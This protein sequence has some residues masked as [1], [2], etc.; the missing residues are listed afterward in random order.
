MLRK[1]GE[2]WKIGAVL[3]GLVT[4]ILGVNAY[5]YTSAKATTTHGAMDKRITRNTLNT[6]L[7]KD[8]NC[9]MAID[10]KS[11]RAIDICTRKEPVVGQP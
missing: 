9:A 11:K 8:I 6:K 7:L 2:L 10:A 4:A 1:I 5:F 3:I